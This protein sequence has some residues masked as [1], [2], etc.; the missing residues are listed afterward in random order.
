MAE[1]DALRGRDGAVATYSAHDRF[2]NPQGLP[3]HAYGL[4]PFVRLQLGSCPPATPGVYA[5]VREGDIL[6]VGKSENLA[7]RWGRTNYAVIDPR[8]CY[9]GGQS[10]NCRINN[11]IGAELGAGRALELWT[12]ETSD[13]AS[14][15]TAVYRPLLPPWNVRVL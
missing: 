13:P 15:E 3:L 2:A 10:T 12:H 11:L 9:Q 7:E 5:V 14:V 6:Y 8:N 4:G 1:I